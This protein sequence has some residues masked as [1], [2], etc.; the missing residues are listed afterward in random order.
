VELLEAISD[1]P[2]WKPMLVLREGRLSDD[3]HPELSLVGT[4]GVGRNSLSATRIAFVAV[5]VVLGGFWR[6]WVRNLFDE[7]GADV[8]RLVKVLATLWT[9]VTGDF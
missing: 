3:V 5:A 1:L 7:S 2:M 6:L 9:A 8:L 4:V